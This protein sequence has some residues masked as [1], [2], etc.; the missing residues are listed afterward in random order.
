V[1]CRL[2][3]VGRCILIDFDRYLLCFC[4][5]CVRLCVVFFVGCLVFS[6]LNICF[7][8]HI[9]YIRNNNPQS[10]YAQRILQ[11]QH[12][13]GQMNSIMTLL[14][15]LNN[16]NLLIPYE[17]YYIQTLYREDKLIPEQYPGKTNPLFQMGI[18]PQPPHTT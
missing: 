4:N 6:S 2:I 17:Q 9:R 15:S 5:H 3:V 8:E 11:N 13:Y 7:Q 16:P 18:N 10:A 12:E 1:F 14:K